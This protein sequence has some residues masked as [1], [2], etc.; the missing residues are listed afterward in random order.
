MKS[1]NS[2][3]FSFC[4]LPQTRTGIHQSFFNI[5]RNNFPH[6]FG[7]KSFFSTE[8][9]DRKLKQKQK[10]RAATLPDSRSFDFLRDEVGQILADRLEDISKHKLPVGLDLGCSTG[11]MLKYLQ[12]S[13]VGIQ[14]LYQMDLSSK[15]LLFFNKKLAL[16][17][18]LNIR[19][20]V[21]ERCGRRFKISTQTN[22]NSRR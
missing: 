17:C 20:N 19:A 10:D 12:D 21:I 5:T 18:F 13:K 8:I 6:S 2:K 15:L 1:W 7:S 9:F 14:T 11:N 16:N 22:S 3:N 4:N